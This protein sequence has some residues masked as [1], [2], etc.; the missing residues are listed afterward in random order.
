MRK[1]YFFKGKQTMYL[2]LWPIK[3][4]R[5]NV[6]KKDFKKIGPSHPKLI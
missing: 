6:V 5:K 3:Y 2:N 1:I 4:M